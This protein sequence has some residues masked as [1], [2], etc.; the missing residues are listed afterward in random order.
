MMEAK[1]NGRPTMAGIWKTYRLRITGTLS[2]LT[3]E[4][5]LGVAVPFV[6][7]VAIN[8]LIAGGF[9]GVWWLVGLEVGVLII[10][11]VRRL[12]DTRVYAGIYTDIADNAAQRTDIS[13]SR[14]LPA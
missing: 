2:L 8:D 11:T 7:G 10:G 13:V 14:P 3:V 4:R 6:L 5:M 12:Y 9:R 1:R